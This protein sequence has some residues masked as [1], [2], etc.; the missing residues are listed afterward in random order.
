[1]FGIEGLTDFVR[2]LK[3]F[4]QIDHFTA[5]RAKGAPFS[6]EPVSFLPTLRTFDL[7]KGFHSPSIQRTGIPR[8]FR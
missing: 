7:W 4:S 8:D 3:P 1:M 5:F 6:R 2:F